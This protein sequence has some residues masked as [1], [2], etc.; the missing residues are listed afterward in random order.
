MFLN[1]V[2]DDPEELVE[3]FD[4]FAGWT[5]RG[6]LGRTDQ[7]DEQHRDIALLTAEFG[8]PFQGSSGD[9]L[10]DIAAEEVTHPLALAELANHVVEARL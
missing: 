5:G 10:P 6:Q 3:Q 2:D 8:A 1:G 9:V 7:V 4:D